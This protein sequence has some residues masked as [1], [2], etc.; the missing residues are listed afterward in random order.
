VSGVTDFAAVVFGTLFSA[1]AL[2]ISLIELGAQPTE[3][4]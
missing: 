1:A 3:G 2:L 4:E